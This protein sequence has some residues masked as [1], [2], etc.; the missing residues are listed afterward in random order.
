MKEFAIMCLVSFETEVY[1]AAENLPKAMEKLARGEVAGYN[2]DWP[3][4][5]FTPL[6]FINPQVWCETEQDYVPCNV[7][8]FPVKEE[9]SDEM[10]FEAD[11]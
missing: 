8:M 9:T 7:I 11:E 2:T 4:E 10:E 5:K 3:E 1:V 6:E